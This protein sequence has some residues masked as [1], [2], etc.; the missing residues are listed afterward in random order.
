VAAFASTASAT[1]A[2]PLAPPMRAVATTSDLASLIAP[3]AGELV[4][5]RTIVSPQADAEA[6]EPRA[7]DMATL[8]DAALVVRVGLGYDFW[9]DRLLARVPRS[10]GLVIVDA[11]LGI[12]LLEV[13]GRDPF[14]RDGHAHSLANPHYWLDPANAETITASIGAAIVQRSPGAKELVLS[15]RRQFLA[16]LREAMVGWEERLA[17][18]RGAAVLA[19]H[20]SWPYFARRFRLNVVGFIQPREGV[21][22]SAAHLASLISLARRSNVRA[23]LQKSNEPTR[24]SQS[25]SQ[26]TGAPLVLLAPGVGSVPQASD[27][28][29]LIEHNVDTLARALWAGR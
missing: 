24:Y 9:L 1:Q 16:R 22:P 5:V 10:E 17:P 3:V 6:F 21:T 23:I 29:S 8:A 4:R 7:S 19:Y 11:S 28:L 15:N 20:N 25:V 27:Y 2:R 26:H 12:P 18:Y 14:A 13:K